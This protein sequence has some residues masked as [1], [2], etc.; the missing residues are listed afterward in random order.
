M[1]WGITIQAIIN[2]ITQLNL[3]KVAIRRAIIWKNR[4][5]CGKLSSPSSLILKY[6]VELSLLSFGFCYNT[7]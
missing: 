7:V 3:P 2:T 6:I 5:T 4:R 1:L